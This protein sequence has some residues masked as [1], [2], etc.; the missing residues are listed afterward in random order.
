MIPCIKV[1]N[2]L[3][4]WEQAFSSLETFKAIRKCRHITVVYFVD[5]IAALTNI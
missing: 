2:K 5:R 3:S 4:K 1:I